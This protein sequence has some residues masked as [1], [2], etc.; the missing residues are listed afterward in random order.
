MSISRPAPGGG[1]F[2]FLAGHGLA[3][4]PAHG[5]IAQ[6]PAR[7]GRRSFRAA[8]FNSHTGPIEIRTPGG[9]REYFPASRAPAMTCD[10][11]PPTFN[12]GGN[13]ATRRWRVGVWSARRS[14]E[15]KYSGRNPTMTRSF[16]FSSLL[17]S[18]LALAGGAAAAPYRVYFTQ[19]IGNKVGIIDPAANKV[20]GD[21]APGKRPR[22]IRAASGKLYVTLSGFPIA[23]PGVDEDKLP[24]PDKKA[25]GIAVIDAGSGKLTATYRGVS[26]PEQIA[27]SPGGKLYTGSEVSE[28]V[29]IF[30]AANGKKLGSVPIPGT[31]EGVAA[32]PDGKFVYA[33][34]EDGGKVYI[35][36]AA[37][38]KI[39][40]W[41]PVG[42][43]PRSVAFSPDG[44]R[45]Y[46]TAELGKSLT[47]ID[48][49]HQTL[50]NMLKLVG[51]PLLPMGVA[52]SPDNKRVY[53]TTGRGGTL[54][55]VDTTSY[56]V[57]ATIKVGK[58]PW[59]V[60]VSP[61]GK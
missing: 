28:A 29:E 61:D 8:W 7:T 59:G 40:K 58:R 25:D 11:L 3:Q 12:E 46:V 23:G 31:P 45:A 24:P 56:R 19:E 51:D 37:T 55:V 53:V 47:I 14:F 41:L 6:A 20:V 5:Q 9:G 15:P 30:N 17:L 50:L 42:G 52:V 35:V 1:G 16:V 38:D 36:D 33:T 60:A 44:A 13:Y 49:R 57:T 39:V 54:L 21:I 18:V 26:N 10:L 43:R 2:S 48:A 22:G 32:T 4:G 27:V 34:S